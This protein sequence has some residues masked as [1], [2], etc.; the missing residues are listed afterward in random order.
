MNEKQILDCWKK[1]ARPWI[2]AIAQQQIDSRVMATNQAIVD[3][4]A[5]LPGKHV[6]DVGCG[7][8]WL[9]Q[10]LANAGYQVLGI[11]ASEPL[12]AQANQRQ[13]ATFTVMAYEDIS[14]QH[15][16][17]TFDSAVCNFS[18]IGKDS[19]EQLFSTLPT[20]LNDNA[21]FVVQTLHP[22][23]TCTDHTYQDGWRQGSWQG[24]HNDFTDPAPW[25][26]RTVPSWLRLFTDNGFAIKQVQEPRHPVTGKIASLIIVGELRRK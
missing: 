10:A 19:V 15:I 26:F 17:N 12:I 14:R 24:F 23:Y 13:C 16:I 7:E 22:H 18:L 8:G 1:N 5:T 6:L 11:D 9:A 20:L 25:Y 21:H 2:T 4:M 3:V